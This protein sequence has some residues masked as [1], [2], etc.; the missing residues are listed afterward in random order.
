MLAAGTGAPA[1][2][3]AHIHATA[4]DEMRSAAMLLGGGKC[5]N[6]AANVAGRHEAQTR[7]ELTW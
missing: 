1:G 4:G 6:F 3:F 5:S 7:E 2:D